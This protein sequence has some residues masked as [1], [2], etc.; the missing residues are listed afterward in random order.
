MI[1]GVE[2]SGGFGVFFAQQDAQHATAHV[3]NIGGTRPQ[4]LVVHSFHLLSEMFDRVLPGRRRVEPVRLDRLADPIQQGRIIQE[5]G[6][7]IENGRFA[8]GDLLL[9]LGDKLIQLLAAELQGALQPIELCLGI[10]HSVPIDSK[11]WLPD[12]KGWAEC[13]AR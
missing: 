8:G 6:M 1:E 2:S 5:H 12:D 13:D 7:G 4:V 10:F 3:P 11:G 9:G